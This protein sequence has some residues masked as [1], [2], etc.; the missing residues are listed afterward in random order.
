MKLKVFLTILVI[1]ILCSRDGEAF[2]FPKIPSIFKG[3]KSSLGFTSNTQ[4]A[5]QNKALL[6]AVIQSAAASGKIFNTIKNLQ[7]DQINQNRDNYVN[8]MLKLNGFDGKFDDVMLQLKE[9]K[10]ASQNILKTVD[11]LHTK[12]MNQN[13]EYYM[14]TMLK[15]NG[16]D[17]RFD[18]VSSQVTDVQGKLVDISGMLGKMDGKL[19]T[20]TDLVFSI[21]GKM[22]KFS[23]QV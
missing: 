21:D 13:K 18:A 5:K 22:D 11:N 20:I 9:N 7:T 14:N 19:N 3:V 8:T 4:L 2:K 10:A 15:L 1:V 17:A 16:F 12:Q 6:E 23:E